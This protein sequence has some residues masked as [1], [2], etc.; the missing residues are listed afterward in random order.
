MKG[1]LHSWFVFRDNNEYIIIIVFV[2]LD[3]YDIRVYHTSA[4]I[5]IKWIICGFWDICKYLCIFMDNIFFKILDLF[6]K[7]RN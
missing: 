4:Q 2:L 3:K 7:N 1:G 6:K 5:S